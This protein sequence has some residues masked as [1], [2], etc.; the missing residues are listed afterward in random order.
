MPGRKTTK[1][2][3]E[4]PNP[5]T[6]SIG[7]SKISNAQALSDP[8]MV[9]SRA[10]IRFL[11]VALCNTIA[12]AMVGIIVYHVTH[13]LTIEVDFASASCDAL[14]LLLNII[15]EYIKNG[16]ASHRSVLLLDFGGGFVSMALLFGVAI[17]GV[18][19]ATTRVLNPVN[20][21][22]KVE[23]VGLMLFYNC[24]SLALDIFTLSFWWRSR[25]LLMPS[26]INQPADQLNV[27]SGLLHALVDFMRG[28]SV[29]GTSFWMIY[30]N[31]KG[32]APW[33][34]LK[35]KV[36]GDI[37]GS[38]LLCACVLVSA[39]FLLKESIET[40][41]KICANETSKVE[42][43]KLLNGHDT[44]NESYGSLKSGV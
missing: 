3:Q 43:G 2:T 30:I 27:N 4:A 39:A 33:M 10:R 1:P 31:L 36:H 6:K 29:A 18:L 7:A 28:L 11:A 16:A 9:I 19:N 15:V 22:E 12:P 13:S 8:D 32:E 38:F 5:A 37:F 35:D 23:H 21:K 41:R 20:E 34:D 17:F 40:L 26:G 24:F 42:D 44:P 25:D 14:S